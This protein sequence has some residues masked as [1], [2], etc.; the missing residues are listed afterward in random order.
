VY[1]EDARVARD[2]VGAADAALYR[3]KR[4]GRNAVRVAQGETAAP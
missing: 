1:P 4:E 3:A 2:L